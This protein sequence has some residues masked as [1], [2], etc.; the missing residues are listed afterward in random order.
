MDALTKTN[1]AKS[2]VLEWTHEWVREGTLWFVL[3]LVT[4]VDV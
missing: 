4:C 1:M 2:L 3:V